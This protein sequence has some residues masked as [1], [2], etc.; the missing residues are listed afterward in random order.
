MD[1]VSQI[2]AVKLYATV[3]DKRTSDSCNVK[4]P[5]KVVKIKFLEYTRISLEIC[6]F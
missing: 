2:M 4:L 6:C 5:T 3:V 1:T